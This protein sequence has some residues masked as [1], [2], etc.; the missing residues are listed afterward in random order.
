MSQKLANTYSKLK[1]GRK[2]REVGISPCNLCVACKRSN[3]IRGDID[4]H[5]ESFKA[6]KT[7]I[8]DLGRFLYSSGCI[9]RP[10]LSISPYIS[11]PS[12]YS[13]KSVRPAPSRRFLRSSR[14]QKHAAVTVVNNGPTAIRKPH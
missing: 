14:S 3:H 6:I 11:L 4:W 8:K 10:N 1:R 9:S 5:F 12:N 7:M 13:E 2:R